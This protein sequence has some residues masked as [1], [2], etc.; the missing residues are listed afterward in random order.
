MSTITYSQQYLPHE[1][2]IAHKRIRPCEPRHNG[3]VEHGHR[4][5][6]EWFYNHKSFYDYNDLLIQM[7]QYLNRSNNILIVGIRL[8]IAFCKN[9]SNSTYSAYSINLYKLVKRNKNKVKQCL[10]TD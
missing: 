7:K 6:Q 2:G 9:L 1:H 4:N 10:F 8:E 3:K 5:D